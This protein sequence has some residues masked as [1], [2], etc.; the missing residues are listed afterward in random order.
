MFMVFVFVGIVLG[1]GLNYLFVS[2]WGM[3]KTL[4]FAIQYTSVHTS[5]HLLNLFITWGHR[6]AKF[7][8]SVYRFVMFRATAYIAGIELFHFM[9]HHTHVNYQLLSALISLVISLVN[10]FVSD[11]WLFPAGDEPVYLEV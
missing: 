9:E 5:N 11:K 4:A 7:W 10:Y 2:V 6:K 8:Q 3:N 1:Y